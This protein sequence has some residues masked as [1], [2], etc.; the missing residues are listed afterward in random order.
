MKSITSLFFFFFICAVFSNEENNFDNQGPDAPLKCSN[1][2]EYKACYTY[3]IQSGFK[4]AICKNKQ[5]ECTGASPNDNDL[6]ESGIN[7][8]GLN[9]DLKCSTFREYYKCY[10]HCKNAGFFLPYCKDKKCSCIYEKP[11]GYA[12]NN[13]EIERNPRL[14]CQLGE[15]FCNKHCTLH[16]FRY[17]KCN[18]NHICVCY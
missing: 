6:E 8:D 14:S 12:E 11:N 13:D 16:N 1:R 5:C 15:W 10:E 3:C 9:A 17:G 18:A 4:K 2:L 7:V